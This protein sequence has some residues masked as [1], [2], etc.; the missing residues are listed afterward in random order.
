MTQPRP[1]IDAP[2][3]DLLRAFE[4]IVRYTRGESFL[5]TDVSTYV[6]AATHVALLDDARRELAASGSLTLETMATG[7][8]PSGATH[9][10]VTV[11]GIRERRVAELLMRG[12]PRQAEGF[13]HSA[14]RLARVGYLSRLVDALFALSLLA[15][16]TVPGA[17]ARRS[18]ALSVSRDAERRTH[19]YYGR[20]VRTAT[21]TALQYWFFYAF[22]D[23]RSGFHGANDHEADWE[24]VL[25]YLDRD[26]AGQSVP[27]WAAYAQHDYRGRDLRR[28]WDDARGLERIG[29]HP[30]V[31]VGAGSHASYFRPGE[32][33]AE[34]ELRLPTV[35]KRLADVYRRIVHG[36]TADGSRILPVAFVDY[37]RGDGVVIGE[38]SDRTWTP[39]VIDPPPAWVAGYAGL[40]GVSVQD[41]FHGEDAPAGP[42]YN[43]DGAVRLAWADPIAFAE[44]D[45]EPP[46]S[47]RHHMLT[48][49]IDA[50]D[51]RAEEL[52]TLIPRCERALAASGVDP[53]ARAEDVGET[54]KARAALTALHVERIANTRSRHALSDQLGAGDDAIRN[55]QAHLRRIPMPTSAGEIR[56][57][58]LLEL[59]AAGSIGLLLLALVA[60]LLLAPG[61]GLVAA[62]LVLALFVFV[63]S[64][65]RRR[66]AGLLTVWVRVLALFGV[67][68]LVVTFWQPAVIGIAIAAGLFV[69]RENLVELVRAGRSRMGHG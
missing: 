61:Y 2:A 68:I 51:A 40:W 16:G 41:L 54:V 55:P 25:V 1:A 14:G 48:E 8:V 42:M 67:V 20:V 53:E 58:R 29:D 24:Q 10:Y 47:M 45:D 18:L 27:V 60:A 59:W 5:P 9:E 52:S 28:R 49:R 12:G 36:T 46:P 56:V 6:A 7:D 34:Q 3:I 30:I 50:L 22:N 44:L 11:A 63:E 17:L 39:V 26:E 31:Y 35:V 15:R 69:L 23:W 19:P 13:R 43:S 33:L 66:V 32:Y 62:I 64:T 38:G 65:L 4:P 57:G 21:W 37:A